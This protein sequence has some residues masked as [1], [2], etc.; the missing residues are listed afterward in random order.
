MSKELY[1]MRESDGRLMKFDGSTWALIG[2]FTP[3]NWPIPGTS[4]FYKS[5]GVFSYKGNLY[6]R[7][8]ETTG[9]IRVGKFAAGDVTVVASTTVGAASAFAWTNVV[10][11]RGK[12]FWVVYESLV[13]ILYEFDDN[14]A[15]TYTLTRYN[16][17]VGLTQNVQYNRDGHA[18]R[19]IVHDNQLILAPS[20]IGAV[21][22]DSTGNPIWR[23]GA[24]YWRIDFQPGGAVNFAAFDDVNL[25]AQTFDY[26]VSAGASGSSV[27]G[28][29]EKRNVTRGIVGMFTH[30]GKL[31]KVSPTGQVWFVDPVTNAHTLKFDIRNATQMNV[32][33]IQPGY[34][35]N[36][37]PG[38]SVYIKHISQYPQI[39]PFIIGSRVTWLTGAKAGQAGDV[40]HAYVST[41]DRF[42]VFIVNDSNVLLA[43]NGNLIT[44]T[45]NVKRGLGYQSYWNNDPSG[46]LV[47]PTCHIHAY[48]VGGNVYI[49]IAGRFASNNS[50]SANYNIPTMIIKWNGVGSTFGVFGTTGLECTTMQLSGAHIDCMRFDSYL[51]P[52]DSR[53][54]MIAQA[55]QGASMKHWAW[56]T[57]SEAV[58]DFGSAYGTSSFSTVGNA[59]NMAI[60]S[61]QH[62]YVMDN[63]Q[64]YNANEGGAIITSA[65]KNQAS[66]QTTI[67]YKLFSNDSHALNVKLEYNKGTGW[68]NATT[69]VS[70]ASLNGLASSPTGVAGNIVHAISTDEPSFS[71]QIQY[72]LSIL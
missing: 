66:T 4:D 45:I 63:L 10:N 24:V 64:G 34:A 30:A 29:I 16:T 22:T 58:E 48:E 38:P 23:T 42:D 20:M 69:I 19:L 7:Y 55:G 35:F 67:A 6:T 27:A 70:P 47:G 54:H 31:Y 56:N 11:Y 72:R 13:Q 36:S 53:I 71:G 50:A 61:N 25:S 62:N 9:Q 33:T 26:G 14:G 15:G 46:S 41:S 44:D 18:S 57:T 32:G 21:E 49:I 3:A 28:P 60:T 37:T 39:Y 65:T 2:S 17:A 52:E 12:A 5:P 40:V 8:H 59:S 1:S 68:L 51:D 43:D